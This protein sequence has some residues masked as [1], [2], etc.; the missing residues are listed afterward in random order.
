M[1]EKKK[2]SQQKIEKAFINLIQSQSLNEI[3]VSQI[4]KLA[5]INRTTFYSNYIDIYDLADKMREDMFYN[6]LKLYE[7]EAIKKQHSYDFLKLFKHIKDNQI[8][9]KTM[10]KLKVDFSKY[11]DIDLMNDEAIKYL[12]NT[13]NLDYHLEFFKAGM[14]AIIN[15]WLDSDCLQSPEEM[16]EII[17][18]EYQKRNTL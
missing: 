7:E 13:K 16:I 2:K 4:C 10:Q 5:N 9:Y 3:K 17:K 15:K 6:I 18:T 11:N 12:G 1:K 8:Y 14:N